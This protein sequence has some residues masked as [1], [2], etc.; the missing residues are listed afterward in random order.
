MDVVWH[1][2]YA[3]Y[4]EIARC[5]MFETIDFNI[6]QMRASGYVWPV[7]ELFVRYAAPV[8][9]GQRV[10]VRAE[11][12]EWENRVKILYLVTDAVSGRRLTRGHTVQVAVSVATGQMCLET[13]DILVHRLAAVRAGGTASGA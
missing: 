3:K 7:I 6:P 11:L 8:R 4:F 1:G 2:H 13:P 9:F 12:I 10:R 5:A